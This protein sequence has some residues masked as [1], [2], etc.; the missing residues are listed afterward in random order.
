MTNMRAWVGTV[1]GIVMLVLGGSVGI[2]SA[3]GHGPEGRYL[4]LGDSITFGFA[5]RLED[6]WVPSRFVGYP[7][8][9]DRRSRLTTTNL[10]CPG[11]T[12][13]ALISRTALDGGCFEMR[14]E[15]HDAGFELLHT[16]YPGTQL[17]AAINLVRAGPA[18]KLISLQGGGNELSM[19]LDADDV[20]QC[21]D[22]MLPK[23]TASL[24]SAVTQLR[25]AG[26]QGTV[27]QVGYHLVPG[28]E[29]QLRRVNHAI[30]QAAN[31]KGVT[32][33]DVATP[34]DQYAQRHHGDLCTTGLLERLPDGSCDLH[35]TRTGQRLYATAVARAAGF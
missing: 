10:A 23:I 20:D 9:V 27:V 17:A 21:L 31:S 35:P 6:P 7:E 34:F 4:A 32:F 14:A 8:I 33:A 1:V 26:Y 12:A 24:R 15:A 2:A 30:A 5:P 22:G 19:C 3:C 28:L 25:A 18:P 13:Q 11:Q 29:P 16:P